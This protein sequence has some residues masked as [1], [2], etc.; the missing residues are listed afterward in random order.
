MTAGGRKQDIKISVIMAAYNTEKYIAQAIDSV[1]SQTYGNWEM[2]IVDDGST[3][4]TPQ[5]I[6][7]KSAVDKRIK[8]LRQSHAGTAAAARK[9]ALEYVSGDFVYILDSDDYISTS[10][11]EHC[12]WKIHCCQPD[13]VVPNCIHF[14]RDHV[15]WKKYPPGGDYDQ[16]L[17]GEQ[18]FAYS[19]DWSIHGLFF[20][21]ADLIKATG[22]DVKIINGDEFLARKLLFQANKIVFINDCYFYRF[23]QGS[24]TKSRK[25]EAR[26]F[27]SL[28]TDKDIHAYAIS[29]GMYES[30]VYKCSYKLA[31]SMVSYSMSYLLHRA[32]ASRYERRFEISIL[33]EVY[34]YM[35][36]HA[37]QI[38]DGKYRVFFAAGRG[39]FNGFLKRVSV[40]AAYKRLKQK[41]KV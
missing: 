11:F 9:K 17:N 36:C 13:I 29:Q 31:A 37:S 40:Y 18:G 35:M 30:L 8:V 10:M 16:V 21:K 33:K 6:A 14:S 7:A 2:I 38:Y 27:E 22:I 1:V 12:V 32:H 5:V 26:M 28:L 25:N 19:L 41:C 15:I 23:R 34:D 20:V 4:R 3:D 24:T 39:G